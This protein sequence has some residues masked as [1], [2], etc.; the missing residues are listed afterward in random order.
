[1]SQLGEVE[2]SRAGFNIEQIRERLQ[3]LDAHASAEPEIVAVLAEL[4]V[5]TDQPQLALERLR[6]AL[7]VE[8]NEEDVDLLWKLAILLI[9]EGRTDEATATLERLRLLRGPLEHLGYLEGLLLIRDE[10]WLQ[11]ARK[12]DKVGET[13]GTNAD[14]GSQVALRLAECYRQIGHTQREL[15]SLERAERLNGFS[16]EARLG[17]ARVQ[18]R[19]GAF[20][21]SLANYRQLQRRGLSRVSAEMVHVLIDQNLSLKPILRDWEAVNKALA[22]VSDEDELVDV[23]LLRADLLAI[24]GKLADARVLLERASQRD[25]GEVRLWGALANLYLRDGDGTA[26]R[27]LLDRADKTLGSRSELFLARMQYWA[28]SGDEKAHEQLRTLE[29]QRR[30]FP[31]N[32]QPTIL[33]G[34]SIGYARVGEY[35]DAERTLKEL[36]ANRPDDVLVQRQLLRFAV[37]RGDAGAA[38]ALIERMRRIEGEGGYYWR[39]AQASLDVAM[40]RAG[41]RERLDQARRLALEVKESMPTS[42]RAFV[43]LGQIDQLWGEEE[44]AVENF[45]QAVE[46]GERGTPILYGLVSS[47]TGLGRYNEAEEI[48]RKFEERNDTPLS[49]AFGDLAL[50]VSMQTENYQ[51]AMRI[52]EQGVTAEPKNVAKRLWL[53][54]VQS[55]AGESQAAE[56]SFR[57]ALELDASRPESWI[58]LVAFLIKHKRDEEAAVEI[59][60]AE[61]AVP[62][63]VAT[64][65]SAQ[66]HEAAGNVERGEQQ[67]GAALKADPTRTAVAWKVAEFHL[68]RGQLD[69]SQELLEEI[70][71]PKAEASV[72][73][74]VVAR[75]ALATLLVLRE[76]YP[77]FQRGMALIDANLGGSPRSLNDLRA[78][79]KLLQ[80]QPIR[81]NRQE[82][83]RIFEQLRTQ[84]D[85]SDSDRFDLARLYLA[86]DDWNQSRQLMLVLLG[87][88]PDN[89]QWVSFTVSNMLAHGQTGLACQHWLEQLRKVEPQAFRTMELTA[90]LAVEHQQV[91]AALAVVDTWL[92]AQA[93]P[94]PDKP[95]DPA[96]P[97]AAAVQAA[98]AAV[99]ATLAHRLER[100]GQTAAAEKVAQLAETHFRNVTEQHADAI[101]ALLQFYLVRG[102]ASDAVTLFQ[103]DAERVPSEAAAAVS[104]NMLRSRLL[105]DEQIRKVMD[106]IQAARR[107]KPDSNQLL[108]HHANAALLVADYASAESLYRK[109][110]DRAP[111]FVLARND[112]ALLIAFRGRDAVE[113][114][115]HI[116]YAVDRAGPQ[117]YLLDS[118]ATV[119]LA[120]KRP[121]EALRDLTQAIDDDPSAEKYF[122]LAQTHL[123]LGDRDSAK[124]AYETA[125]KKKL[126]VGVLH[127]LEADQYNA[128]AS[129]VLNPL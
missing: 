65:T 8:R 121:R 76:A 27:A 89:P 30:R 42:A 92:R 4:E 44:N 63:D 49:R 61:K 55:A 24:Q 11:A 119:Y 87:K 99:L 80:T 18:A 33:R 111:D 82:A 126:H 6:I 91:D 9:A 29:K 12:L 73:V 122:H 36:A 19:T 15:A 71:Q 20:D 38:V 47:L 53:G 41:E 75:R 32:V 25:P 58:A 109:L 96:Q 97:S 81:E 95:D 102:R 13:I 23:L 69:K 37:A 56:A 84:G 7:E 50:E 34:L 86:L 77:G 108:L 78:K 90:R 93:K 3:K 51:R 117:A 129:A 40:A 57:K 107:A 48:L 39:L 16:I 74:L 127:P 5:A 60:K 106:W 112:L 67:Y 45:L 31:D 103:Q 66:L 83:V 110:L 43:L 68:R 88:Q 17:L 79:A 21:K 98:A 28:N 105:S 118:R 26:A 14:L 70:V 10:K 120:L 113:A 115:E 64:L 72:R 52:A 59:A 62:T 54:R 1:M 114:L 46:L 116:Q 123:A 125:I 94:D 2:V 85:L 124:E 104:V 128:V 35:A 100:T 22:L 101:P